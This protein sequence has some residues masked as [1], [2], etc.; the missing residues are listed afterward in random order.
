M[1][2]FKRR[3]FLKTSLSL[4]AAGLAPGLTSGLLL[5]CANL[6]KKSANSTGRVVIIGGGYAG[7]TAAKYIRM[8]SA[9][10]IDVVVV[11][12]SNQFVSCPLSN[13]V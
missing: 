6:N 4:G 5:G 1:S 9:D 11:E 10:S 12:K 3:D 2:E 7:L 13:L 8:W